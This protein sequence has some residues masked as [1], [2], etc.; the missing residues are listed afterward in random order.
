MFKV[1][2]FTADV[3]APSHPAERTAKCS[4]WPR[5]EQ[6]NFCQNKKKR[7]REIYSHTTTTQPPSIVPGRT[8][9][10]SGSAYGAGIPTSRP[11][12]S[13][14]AARVKRGRER[15][16]EEDG[17]VDD[18]GS[19]K[20]SQCRSRWPGRSA[21]DPVYNSAK[22]GH[23]ESLAAC[24]RRLHTASGCYVAV[25]IASLLSIRT[26]PKGNLSASDAETRVMLLL[27]LSRSDVLRGSERARQR[28]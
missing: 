11:G 12:G 20:A 26:L 21:R 5:K 9:R 3:S 17:H 18:V 1:P 8:A 19:F 10:K 14:L 16:C 4:A 28:Q 22:T 27:L 25:F 7:K 15:R 2:L 13:P 23:T 6:E 24:A